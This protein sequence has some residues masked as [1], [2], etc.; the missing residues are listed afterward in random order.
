MRSDVEDICCD[1]D[2]VLGN[3][4]SA[5]LAKHGFPGRA[6]LDWPFER[7]VDLPTGL[8]LD[9]NR[10]GDRA[11]FWAPILAD[12]NFWE[13]IEPYPWM[14]E[15]LDF[16]ESI[17]G[18]SHVVICTGPASGNSAEV[19]AKHDWLLR[20]G[21]R[22]E[23]IKIK[24]KWRLSAPGT[25]LIDDWERQV[26]EFITPPRHRRRLWGGLAILFPQPWN[27]KHEHCSDPFE[28]IRSR[29]NH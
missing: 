4:H 21:V 22:N 8:G 27:R 24:E 5:A 6:R 2:G 25:L 14:R 19:S 29:L 9:F 3:F 20:H 11:K 13:D 26:D 10:N 1:L 16:L 15:L 7:G 18:F 12:T 28:Y 23:V 17:V